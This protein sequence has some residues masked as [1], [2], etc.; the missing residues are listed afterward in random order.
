[1]QTIT[2]TIA[3]MHCASCAIRNERSLRKKKGVSQASVNLATHSATIEF[4]SSLVSKESLYDAVVKNGYKVMSDDFVSN[5]KEDWA[6]PQM[7]DW[8]SKSCITHLE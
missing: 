6:V 8:H 4:D 2:F 5:H 1:M 7:Q 3:G